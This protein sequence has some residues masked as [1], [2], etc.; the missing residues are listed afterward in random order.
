MIL[1]FLFS[2][3]GE[4]KWNSK[5]LVTEYRQTNKRA[6]IKNRCGETLAEEREEIN[7]TFLENFSSENW[8]SGI[9]SHL[10]TIVIKT[11]VLIYF[12]YILKVKS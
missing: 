8:M 1:Q 11:T 2:L 3:T 5:F 6:A 4:T 9:Q 12:L 10:V 7:S